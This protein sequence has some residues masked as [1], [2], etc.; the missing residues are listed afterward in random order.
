MIVIGY[1]DKLAGIVVDQLLGEAQTVI[2]PLGK[3]FQD[4]TGITGSTILG[5]GRV[6]FVLDV[7]SMVS[8]AIEEMENAASIE[9]KDSIHQELSS[10]SRLGG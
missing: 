2:K 4:I 7:A 8:T 5:N 9:N 10:S 6:A 3:L 1:G